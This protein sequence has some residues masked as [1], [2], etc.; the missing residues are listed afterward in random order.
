MPTWSRRSLCVCVLISIGWTECR[1]PKS[2]RRRTTFKPRL[3][4]CTLRND[5]RIVGRQ[6]EK[7]IDIGTSPR[8]LGVT[9]F[10]AKNPSIGKTESD[11]KGVYRGGIVPPTHNRISI[12]RGYSSPTEAYISG[13]CGRCRTLMADVSRCLIYKSSPRCLVNT[14]E[15]SVTLCNCE[16]DSHSR[17]RNPNFSPLDEL[18]HVS[19]H[20]CIWIRESPIRHDTCGSDCLQIHRR[21]I[22]G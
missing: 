18:K 9:E 2:R 19:R 7:P 15:E 3:N 12:P 22:E 16:S 11:G 5:Q 4:C 1:H 13:C 20:P 8:V 6:Y 17:Y 10:H 21:S 14:E